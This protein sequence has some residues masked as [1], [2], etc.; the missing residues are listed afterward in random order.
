MTTANLKQAAHHLIDQLPD[1]ST[2]DDLAY[3]IEVRASIER[4][5]AD[6]EAGRLIPQEEI[7][8]HFGITG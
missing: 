4:G 3:Q 2:W 6:S 1:D 8:K 7:E 5:L